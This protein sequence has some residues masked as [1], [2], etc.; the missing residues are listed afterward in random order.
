MLQLPQSGYSHATVTTVRIPKC[1]SYHGQDTLMLQLPQSGYSHA[2]VTTV[3]IL[4][5]Y[6]Y[7]SQDTLM[8]QSPWS[9][10]SHATVTTVRI[11]SCYSYQ[12]QDTLM[13]QLPGSGYS[14]ARVYLS[15]ELFIGEAPYLRFHHMLIYEYNYVI[16]T[17]FYLS[18][19]ILNYVDSFFGKD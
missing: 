9:G 4:S 17:I 2:T 12:G 3:R 6:S 11:L 8:L 15:F 16:N 5:C 1:Y 18:F 13:L 19:F 7:H 10:Y 14:H